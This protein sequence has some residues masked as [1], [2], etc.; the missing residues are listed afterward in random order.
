MQIITHHSG[1]LSISLQVLYNLGLVGG[2][3]AGKQA[4]L[5]HSV[6]LLGG[7][8]VVKLTP[9]V[10]QA[11]RLLGLAEYTDPRGRGRGIVRG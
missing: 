11:G 10:R 2:L 5:P 8:Q 3:H 4:G 1:D 9:G 6:G 7:G